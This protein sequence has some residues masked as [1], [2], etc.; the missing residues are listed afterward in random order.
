MEQDPQEQDLYAELTEKLGEL[1]HAVHGLLTARPG[2]SAITQNPY[3]IGAG[4]EIEQLG[5]GSY[6]P[7]SQL[8]PESTVTELFVRLLEPLKTPSIAAEFET[9]SIAISPNGKWVYAASAGS[10]A[11]NMYSVNEETGQLTSLG[12]VA[13]GTTPRCIVVS[14]DGK[15]AYVANAGS[16]TISQYEISVA[17][18]KLTALA[19]A[20]IAS[21]ATP[22]SIWVHP[23]GSYVYVVC[24]G[25]NEVYMYSRN[26]I[27]GQLTALG[28]PT[29]A[30]GTEPRMIAGTPDG[31][32]AYV[33]N[34]GTNNITA[35]TCNTVTGVLTVL[36]TVATGEAPFGIGVSPDSANVYVPSE[37]EGLI[38]QYRRSTSTGSLSSLAPATVSTGGNEPNTATVSP[39]GYS[40]YSTNV[41]T[42]SDTIA[43]FARNPVTGALTPLEPLD[44]HCGS[45]PRSLIVSPS[46]RFVYVGAQGSKEVFMF[47][48]IPIW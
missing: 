15:N 7:S 38:H 33:V 18:G 48:R 43:M 28:T 40:L 1:Q 10:T 6:I 24:Q 19:Q 21:G 39:D 46:K 31:K 4:G 9:F 35:L 5:E 47:R 37:K 23:T 32:S 3:Y 2:D 17:T 14:P 25:V 34:S 44:I 42:S 41:A 11:I 8:T 36:E 27:T 20:T 16:A 22:R 30:T 26:A 12:T 13:A 45:E 29:V